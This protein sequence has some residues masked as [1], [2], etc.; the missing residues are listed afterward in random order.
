MR[1]QRSSQEKLWKAKRFFTK[2]EEKTPLQRDA[3]LRLGLGFLIAKDPEDA[4]LWL[5][6]ISDPDSEVYAALSYASF[7]EKNWNETLHYFN[8]TLPPYHQLEVFKQ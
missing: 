5:N 3:Y 4:K 1:F 7:L 6:K 2:V 8:Q